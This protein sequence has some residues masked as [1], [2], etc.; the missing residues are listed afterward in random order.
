M[1]QTPAV[2]LKSKPAAT[3]AEYEGMRDPLAGCGVLASFGR[4]GSCGC[5][6]ELRLLVM[7][8]GVVGGSGGPASPEHA[9]PAGADAP[10]CAVVQLAAG[11]CLLVCLSGP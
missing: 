3:G 9:C 10:Q 5:C 2:N 11:A 6:R 1:M 4:V 8:C 7:A